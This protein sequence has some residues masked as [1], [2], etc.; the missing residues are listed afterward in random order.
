MMLFLF[1]VCILAM[2]VA[3]HRE[4]CYRYA[5]STVSFRMDGL[6]KLLPWQILECSL[7]KPHCHCYQVSI[8]KHINHLLQTVFLDTLYIIYTSIT[9]HI[10]TYSKTSIHLHMYVLCIIHVCLS[11]GCRT[12][13]ATLHCVTYCPLPR[14]CR[15]PTKQPP[16]PR[17]PATR[18]L[19][20]D[21]QAHPRPSPRLQPRPRP[22]T[23]WR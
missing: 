11:G 20:T 2:L 5:T 9:L 10:T 15:R 18:R 23:Q 4:D 8:S 3:V 6:S 12:P 1:L 21:S 17:P 14:T 19:C 16:R 13:G 22:L 7:H